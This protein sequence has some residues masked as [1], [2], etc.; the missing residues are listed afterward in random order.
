MSRP[1]IHWVGPLPPARTDIAAMTAR[2]LPALSQRADVVLWTD[3]EQWDPDLAHLA[4]VRRYDAGAHFPMPLDGLPP[5]DGPE[6]IFFQIGNSWVFHAGP[7]NLARRVPGVV[8]LHDLALQDL[9]RGMI[10]FGHFDA[11]VYRRE[12]ADWYGLPGRRAADDV[13]ADR[14]RPHE[15]AMRYPFF[16]IAFP[17]AVAAMAHTEAGVDM[18]AARGALPVYGLDLPFPPGPER[19]AGRAPGGPLKLVQFGYLAPNRR[20][21]QVLEAL[22]GLRERLDFRLE[23]FG[24]LWDEGHVRGKI[25]ELHLTDRV[26]L[27]GYAPEG[28]LDAAL[29]AAHLVFNL[30]HPTMGEAS[31]S[32]L[33]IW[34]AA[35][36]SVV[37]ETGW[38][39]H[40]PDDCAFKIPVD[41]EVAALSDLLTRLD[42]DRAE[43][44]RIGA[45][46]RA[47]LNA[48]HAPERY[49]QG[50]VEAAARYGMDARDALMAQRA[51]RLLAEMP[52]RRLATRRLAE[53]LESGG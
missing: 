51:L 49:A 35:A 34:A 40:L 6:A 1:R 13:L 22:G 29:A 14:V 18:V 21:D 39:A 9:L 8:V 3:A 48:C 5:A 24:T 12:M 7:L 20:L 47:R 53:R 38:Y 28:E 30:R 43:G 4:T 36:A 27:R 37:S 25:A 15:A 45:A 44:A 23:I 31:G 32:Q 41:G 46:G 52:G 2:I 17:K 16:E 50:L 19:P 26:A 33:R 11:P 10:E 42:A